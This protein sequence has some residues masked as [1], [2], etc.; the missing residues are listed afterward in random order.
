MGGAEGQFLLGRLRGGELLL[1]LVLL[2]GVGSCEKVAG[3][4]CSGEVLTCLDRALSSAIVYIR[5]DRVGLGGASRLSRFA[6][7]P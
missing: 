7:F 2:V 3:C 4:I 5:S 1:L 6:F